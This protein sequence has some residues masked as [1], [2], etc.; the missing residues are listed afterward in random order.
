LL[1]V[2]AEIAR[3]T[4]DLASAPVDCY[5]GS[6]RGECIVKE[7]AEDV[8]LVA[9]A[10]GVLLPNERIGRDAKEGFPVVGPQGGQVEE[11]PC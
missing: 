10:V 11:I 5:Q 2:V 6:S 3:R 4:D 9:I 7:A 1:L 8:F